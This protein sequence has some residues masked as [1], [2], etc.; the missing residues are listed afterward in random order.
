VVSFFVIGV[1]SDM[2]W[3][4]VGGTARKWLRRS[5]ERLAAVRLAGGVA[6]ILLGLYLFAHSFVL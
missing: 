1:A 2:V 5:L 3:A 4:V 6:L